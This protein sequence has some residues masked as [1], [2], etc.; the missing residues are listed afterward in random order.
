MRQKQEKRPEE[1]KKR[2]KG[3]L[4]LKRRGRRKKGD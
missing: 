1:K 2:E 4:R 3:P